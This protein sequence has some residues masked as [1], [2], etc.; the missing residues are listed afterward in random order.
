MSESDP[1]S[2]DLLVHDKVSALE[3]RQVVAL[4]A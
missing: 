2:A 3:L 4:T 1:P